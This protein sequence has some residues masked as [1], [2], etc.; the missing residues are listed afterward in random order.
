MY[1]EAAASLREILS[2]AEKVA[3]T[4]DAWKALI[5]ESC[6]TVTFLPTGLC[7]VRSCRPA[8]Y[9]RGTLRKTWIIVSKN[10]FKKQKYL[11]VCVCKFYVFYILNKK[12][13]TINIRIKES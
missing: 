2:L 4:I 13:R 10:V 1:S 3:I 9:Q 7:R 5:M 12:A 6:V 8:Q 11:F